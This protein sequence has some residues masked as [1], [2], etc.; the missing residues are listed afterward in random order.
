MCGSLGSSY[1]EPEGD[2]GDNITFSTIEGSWIAEFVFEN[3]PENLNLKVNKF[4][5]LIFVWSTSTYSVFT[6]FYVY[7]ANIK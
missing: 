4:K 2:H 6:I 7:L 1:D 5:S 3:C